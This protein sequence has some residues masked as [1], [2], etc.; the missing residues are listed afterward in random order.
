LHTSAARSYNTSPVLSP[1]TTAENHQRSPPAPAGTRR[2]FCSTCRPYPQPFQH[3]IT[4]TLTTSRR[5]TPTQA[6]PSTHMKQVSDRSHDL[7]HVALLPAAG[8]PVKHRLRDD[9]AGHH[10]AHWHVG[11]RCCKGTARGAGARRE[12]GRST[13]S[14]TPAIR[15][16]A[17]VMHAETRATLLR[18]S[19]AGTLRGCAFLANAF[20]LP[21]RKS[22]GCVFSSLEAP[23][24]TVQR[25]YARPAT[26][27]GNPTRP[28]TYRYGSSNPLC[29]S[30]ELLQ[31]HDACAE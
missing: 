23:R 26:P 9:P 28:D 31:R 21:R 29:S 2:R 1:G 30:A 13:S 12:S 3:T 18:R 11:Q 17:T 20:A 4:S 5:S 8:A 24:Y 7:P 16:P 22:S 27:A 14:Q 10:G 25:A 19:T 6:P 15:S